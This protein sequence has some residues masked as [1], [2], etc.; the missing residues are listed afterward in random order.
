MSVSHLFRQVPKRASFDDWFRAVS[1][2]GRTC[3]ELFEMIQIELGL[4]QTAK[5]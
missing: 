5:I 4:M 3:N 1:N 2:N